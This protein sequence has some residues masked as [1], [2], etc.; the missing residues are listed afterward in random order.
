MVYYKMPAHSK[1]IGRISA[2][3]FGGVTF[4]NASDD[5]LEKM[6]LEAGRLG[7]NGIVLDDFASKA[8]DGAKVR[9][10][11]IFVSP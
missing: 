10:S 2:D 5:A 3:S 7:A 1:I 8:L 11:T 9:G 4:Q 6:K